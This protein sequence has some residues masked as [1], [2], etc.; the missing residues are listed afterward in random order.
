M[1]SKL[2]DQ[3]VDKRL[4]ERNIRK[5]LIDR[6]GVNKH[7]ADTKD[8]TA[9]VEMVPYYD[10]ETPEDEAVASESVAREAAAAPAAVAPAAAAPA[11]V[12]PAAVAPA[13]VAPAAVAPAA[14]TEEA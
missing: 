1:A 7:I 2:T 5:G 9:N 11:A 13:A 10:P 8:M 6:K 12:A 14:S 4:V 3:V